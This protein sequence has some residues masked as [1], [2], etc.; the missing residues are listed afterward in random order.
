MGKSY[1]SALKEYFSKK[2]EKVHFPAKGSAEHSEIRKL[3][4]SGDIASGS[5]VSAQVALA[6]G[7]VK[8]KRA[9]KAVAASGPKAS[10]EAKEKPIKPEG[11]TLLDANHVDKGTVDGVLENAT[12][13]PVVKRK[14]RA[15]KANGETPQSNLLE[16]LTQENASMQAVPAA[17]P[18]LKEQI[19]AILAV[20][21]EGLPKKPKSDAKPKEV[22]VEKL[23]TV[24]PMSLGG[25][26]VPFS[27]AALKQ[28]IR[29]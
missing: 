27:F 11:T 18:G 25:G 9:G 2:G 16:S 6:T 13:K 19:E 4:A 7:E 3:M 5:G 10:E 15:V 28:R 23:R 8:K 14:P 20:K 1:A 21:P 12:R 24:D 29:A 26:R 17:Y 22:T